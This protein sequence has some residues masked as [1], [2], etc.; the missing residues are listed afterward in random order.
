MLADL[1]RGAVVHR[2]GGVKGDAA[3]PVFVVVVAK[4]RSQNARASGRDPKLPG[5]AEAYFRVL[6]AASLN[7]LSLLT[8]GRLWLRATPRSTSSCA[9]GLEVMDVPRSACRLLGG[10]WT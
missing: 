10:P 9:T 8:C 4:K 3:V 7:G 5:K 2:G 1:G 6:N